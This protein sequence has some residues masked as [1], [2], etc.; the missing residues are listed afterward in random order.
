MFT[1]HRSTLP[2]ALLL[3]LLATVVGC[4][5]G[6]FGYGQ[7]Y[8]P[9]DTLRVQGRYLL[10]TC[11]N[12]LVIRGVEQP[13]ASPFA[14]Q[15]QVWSL[16]VTIDEIARTGANAVRLLFDVTPGEAQHFD[17]PGNIERIIDAAVR[18]HLV[19]YI[20]GGSFA[21]QPDPDGSYRSSYRAWIGQDAIK[22]IVNRY[23]KWVIV[24]AGGESDAATPEAWREEAIQDILAFRAMG[25]TV[26][27]VYIGP[28][29]GRD[30]ATILQYGAAVERADP[31]HNTIIGW[32]A[33]WGSSNW[34]QGYFGGQM[35]L[36]VPSSIPNG[37]QVA[38][39]QDFPIQ[40]GLDFRSDPN[41]IC[42]YQGGM[43]VAGE[44]GVGW[45][46]WAYFHPLE[47]P[48]WQNGLSTDGLETNLRQPYGSA[49]VSTAP[50][51]L[52]T[53]EKACG[54]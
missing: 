2:H 45:L 1:S 6:T 23:Q 13:M 50:Y 22:A 43:R 9:S 31:L 26:P 38:S 41:E 52:S 48:V 25:Y 28:T 44:N 4:Q 49:V 3:I 17:D 33:Y 16:Y 39:T 35:G 37:V 46:W 40:V 32:Q 12:P 7:G 51:A 20:T 47:W 19:V 42:D 18:N 10:D 11:G 29:G 24:D 5:G 14:A 34:Y 36:S 15:G 21:W 30:L 53:A 54:T 8:G 27:L